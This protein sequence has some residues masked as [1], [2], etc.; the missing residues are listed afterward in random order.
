MIEVV[1]MPK[2]HPDQA[3]GNRESVV[4]GDSYWKDRLSKLK[5]EQAL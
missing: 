1:G 3:E 5:T 4:V 2:P